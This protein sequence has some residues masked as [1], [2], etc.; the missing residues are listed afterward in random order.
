MPPT[1]DVPLMKDGAAD[2][3]VAND[4]LLFFCP[5]P[6]GSVVSNVS[7]PFCGEFG[8]SRRSRSGDRA[9]RD[10][11]AETGGANPAER[12]ASDG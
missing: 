6:Y 11:A 9:G 8:V 5:W 2:R 3:V 10:G 1:D 4:A 7:I 12:F